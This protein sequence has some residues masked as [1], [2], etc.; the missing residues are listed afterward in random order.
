MCCASPGPAEEISASDTGA[1]AYWEYWG[2]GEVYLMVL[3][4]SSNLHLQA[5]G[6]VGKHPRLLLNLFSF[7]HFFFFFL[8]NPQI[9][10]LNHTSYFSLSENTSTAQCSE[11]RPD[12]W[13]SLTSSPSSPFNSPHGLGWNFSQP[14]LSCQRWQCLFSTYAVN[15]SHYIQLLSLKHKFTIGSLLWKYRAIFFPQLVVFMEFK[16]MKQHLDSVFRQ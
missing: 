11:Q 6:A 12:R 10:T 8:T 16:S 14:L 9:L 4:L 2:W 5:S 13:R 1:W 15:I 3:L 7:V